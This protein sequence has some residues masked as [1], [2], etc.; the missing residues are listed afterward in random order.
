M[1]LRCLPYIDLTRFSTACYD[2]LIATLC[3]AASYKKLDSFFQMV[4]SVLTTSCSSFY[5][6]VIIPYKGPPCQALLFPTK[7]AAAWIPAFAG[8]T[9]LGAYSHVSERLLLEDRSLITRPFA[10][11]QQATPKIPKAF[12]R[13]RESRRANSPTAHLR[14]RFRLAIIVFLGME[15][16]V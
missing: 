13:K 15:S 2:N 10:V 1:S 8:M 6:N 7:D 12:P 14:R 5:A 16:P 3:V 9:V 4:L 11:A